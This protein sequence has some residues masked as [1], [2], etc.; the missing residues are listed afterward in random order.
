[1]RS[2]FRTLL[3]S[4]IAAVI[5]FII[6]GMIVTFIFVGSIGALLDGISVEQAASSTNKVENNSLVHM[7]LNSM[8][9]ERTHT[10]FNPSNLQVDNL[11]GIDAIRA[12]LKAAKE[13]ENIKGIYLDL[14]GFAVGISTL[15]EIRQALIDFKKSNKFIVAYSEAYFQS[16]Y[17]LASVADEMYIYPE[18]MMDF[19]GLGAELMFFKPMLD[20]WG[21]DMQVIRGSNNK[22]KSAVEPF[23]SDHMS[24]AN[25]AQ[26]ETL[27]GSM[28]QHLKKGIEHERGIS[29]ADL[30]MIA[31]SV[32]VTSAADA[33]QYKMIDGEKYKDE[34]IDLLK[35]K[36]GVESID[37]MNILEFNKYAKKILFKERENGN[38]NGNIAIVYATGSIGSG[39]GDL[40]TIGSEGVSKA[41][42]AARLNDSVKAVVFRV[43]SPGGSALASDVIWREVKLLE[44]TD[45]PIIVS[46][47]DYAAS[48]GYY[49]SCAAD[50][51]YAQ[52]NTV[53]GSIGVFGVIPNL[54]GFLTNEIG[55]TTDRVETNEYSTLTVTKPLSDKELLL[56]QESVDEVYDV[57]KGRVADGREGLDVAGVD[58][59]GQ[60][61]VWS[62]TNALEI[63]LIDE[64]G[65]IQDAID[66]AAE[67]AEISEEDRTIIEYPIIEVNKFEALI[68]QLAEQMEQGNSDNDPGL[69]IQLMEQFKALDEMTQMKGIQA[70]LPFKMTFK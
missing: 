40:E 35:V 31:D 21:V 3:A 47:G 26:M 4:F 44:E 11:L 58:S 1:M 46:M 14:S 9:S 49:I 33:I 17:Y 28:W 52:A 13:D 63:G 51:I 59:I 16:N 61:R 34:I 39:E 7:N 55:I 57:F 36:M 2:F 25:R 50:K 48:G 27:L 54:E 45:K 66:Y 22:F 19:R 23:L 12:G 62:G 56:M 68:E 15:E 20:K 10:S 43:N 53:T 6:G 42:R 5:A 69:S 41:L 29:L 38:Q 65:G 37:D 64:I 70:R 67:L 18:G 8:I 30:D 24:D 32:L 60:G